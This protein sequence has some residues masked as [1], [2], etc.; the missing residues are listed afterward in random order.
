VKDAPVEAFNLGSLRKSM[1]I[2]FLGSA[3]V[4][5]ICFSLVG[6]WSSPGPAPVTAAEQR[7]ISLVLRDVQTRI[8]KD[9]RLEGSKIS[10][11]HDGG[12]VILTGTVKTK[13][14]F[15][16]AS[17]VAAGTPGVK[18]VINRLQVEAEAQTEPGPR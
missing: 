13:E 2:R 10:I 3:F 11:N 8:G 15:G 1:L 18:G 4:L 6:C 16:W 5:S 7:P 17:T 14:Q 12:T 9:T